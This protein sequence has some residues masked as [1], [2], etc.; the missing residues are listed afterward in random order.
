MMRFILLLLCVPLFGQTDPAAILRQELSAGYRYEVSLGQNS[1]YLN[2]AS[3]YALK[4]SYR[5]LRSLALEAGM[6]QIP[7]PIGSAVCYR[8]ESSANDE[9]FLLP[10]GARYVWQSKEDRL[11]LSIGGGGAYLN[12]AIGHQNAAENLVGASGWG[13]QFVVGGDY[14]LTASGRFRLG[15]TARYYYVRMNPYQNAR[16]V[17][18]GPDFTFSFR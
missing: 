3:G 13:G 17:T 14:A 1:Y 12:H 4:Y 8:Y 2:N 10:F 6:E 15:T 9:L 11:R 18:I 7:R 5:P 16:I